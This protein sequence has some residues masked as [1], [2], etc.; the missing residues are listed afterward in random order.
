MLSSSVISLT[1]NSKIKMTLLINS[2]NQGV[3]FRYVPREGF[4]WMNGKLFLWGELTS[5]AYQV[6]LQCLTTG[7]RRAVAACTPVRIVRTC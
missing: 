1:P 6:G 7:M 2:G 5:A 3:D 4:G